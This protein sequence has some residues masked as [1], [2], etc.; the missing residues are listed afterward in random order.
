MYYGVSICLVSFA[1]GLSVLTLNIHHRG[2]RGMEVPGL[3]RV[4]VLGWL[5]KLVFLHF[6]PPVVLP[7]EDKNVHVNVSVPLRV[8]WEGRGRCGYLWLE[9]AV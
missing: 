1:S 4:V 9:G 5:S 2:V 8:L 3:V 6:E 7:Q